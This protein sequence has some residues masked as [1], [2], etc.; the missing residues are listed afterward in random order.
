MVNKFRICGQDP[1]QNHLFYCTLHSTFCALIL[2]VER[3]LSCFNMQSE[4]KLRLI[5][6][7]WQKSMCTRVMSTDEQ[8]KT[9]VKV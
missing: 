9:D 2:E 3:F 4:L 1:S 8:A 6:L 5:K 7:N